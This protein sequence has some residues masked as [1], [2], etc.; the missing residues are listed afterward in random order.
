MKQMATRL[1]S[2]CAL[3]GMMIPAALPQPA[4]AQDIRPLVQ[5]Y[6]ATGL[7]LFDKLAAE[8]GNIVLSPYSIGTAMAMARSGA[9]GATEAQMA[10]VLHHRLPRADADAANRE[11]LAILNR[12]YD[13]SA[14]AP[15]C[16][17]GLQWSGQR[18]EGAV[19]SEPGR[20]LPQ[21]PSTARREGDRCIADPIERPAS[22]KLAV[23]NALML[24]GT[25]QYVSPAYQSLVRDSYAAEVFASA[26]LEQINAWVNEKTEGKIAQM[27]A[28]LDPNTKA[29]LLNA[30]YF[31]A[32]WGSMFSK[33][34]TRN[35]AFDV[36]L[37][38]RADVPT[39]RQ[40]TSFVVAA[41]QSYRAIRLSYDVGSLAMIVVL[42]DEVDGLERVAKGLDANE[43][44][45]LTDALNAT[46]ARLVELTLPRF[47]VRFDVQLAPAFRQL[48]MALAFDDVADFSGM[49][50]RP[51]STGSLKI[52]EI[53]HRAFI[54]VMEEG[55]EAA[56]ATAVIAYPAGALAQREAPP[57]P[58]PFHVDHPFLFFVADS[59]T[60]A[61]L[62][63]G[64]V[65]DPR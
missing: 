49:T 16:E 47:K 34:A 51:V 61:V 29:V 9:R 56:A 7:N 60:G 43:L 39:M 2:C 22:A 20:G 5:A 12:L 48:G 11:L 37:S 64:R 18:C 59:A 30:I 46:P 32:H 44:S 58:E 63:Q 19:L 36:A 35:E 10:S 31:K 28:Q 24:T 8:P 45:A 4:R 17:R 38:R 65:V 33:P 40:T 21:C 54:E 6:N 41:R 53:I 15:T 25:G 27:L 13:K 50:G 14:T 57:Q 52:D 62:F 3:A 42:P 1:M 55:T 26:G 23:A